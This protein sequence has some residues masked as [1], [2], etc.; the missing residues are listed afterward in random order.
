MWNVG[1]A[2]IFVALLAVLVSSSVVV[3]VL[4]VIATCGGVAVMAATRQPSP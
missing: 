3:A 2:L 1:A 4:A